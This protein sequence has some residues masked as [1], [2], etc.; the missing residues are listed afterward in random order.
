MALA[1]LEERI[2]STF[3]RDLVNLL[4]EP[5]CRARSCCGWFCQCLICSWRRKLS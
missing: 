4:G 2:I 3:D 1:A 5:D